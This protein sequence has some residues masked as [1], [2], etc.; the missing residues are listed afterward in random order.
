M[1]APSLDDAIDDNRPTSDD[2]PRIDID[3]LYDNLKMPERAIHRQTVDLMALAA[4]RLLGDEVW[5]FRDLNWYPPD[6]GTA[7][8]PDIM[9]L[10]RAALDELP[11]SYRQDKTGGPPPLAVVEIASDDD[12]YARVRAKARR[13]QQLGSVFYLVVVENQQSDDDQ[14]VLRLGA[15]DAELTAWTG[16]PIP[17]LGDIALSFTNGVPTLTL[18][19]GTTA[20]SDA[21]LV[22]TAEGRADAAEGRA[23]AAE[24]RVRALEARLRDLGAEPSG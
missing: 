6:G 12:S 11:R 24:A 3:A 16:R 13:A 15:D 17:E 4:T 23:D 9:V 1:A 14:S 7:T 20:Q 5:I 19:D 21:D 22:A 2:V 18:P 10:P 8:A